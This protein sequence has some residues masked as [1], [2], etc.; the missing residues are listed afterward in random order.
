[1]GIIGYCP[2]NFTRRSI[3][4]FHNRCSKRE[5]YRQCEFRNGLPACCL[6][7]SLNLSSTL[8]APNTASFVLCLYHLR[9]CQH[10]APKRSVLLWTMGI[11]SSAFGAFT[12]HRR[13][14]TYFSKQVSVRLRPRRDWT[15][16]VSC[17]LSYH[18]SISLPAT[19][20]SHHDHFVLIT[21]THS[22]TVKAPSNFDPPTSYFRTLFPFFRR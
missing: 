7:S 18:H 8:A 13:R 19:V 10:P 12:E 20:Y 11:T 22:T 17:Q 16:Q 21:T 15:C 3:I 9:L 14:P 6:Q 5:W 1:M 4:V 2:T